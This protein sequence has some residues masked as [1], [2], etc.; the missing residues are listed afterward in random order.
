MI[1]RFGK[2]E[3]LQVFKTVDEISENWKTSSSSTFCPSGTC[4][5]HVRTKKFKFEPEKFLYYRARAITCDV[6]NSNG[7]YF[8][9]EEVKKAYHTFIGKGVYYN[10]DADSVDKSFG[11]ILDA[12]FSPEYINEWPPYVE[13]LACIDKQDI[14]KKRPGL[15]SKIIEGNLIGTS[16][17][18]IAQEAQCSYCSHRYSSVEAACDHVR[19][20]SPKYCKGSSID[21]KVVYENNFGLTFV[22][23]SIVPCPADPTANILKILGS[24]SLQSH[25]LKYW[26]IPSKIEME[27][28]VIKEAQEKEEK[29]EKGTDI[30][31]VLYTKGDVEK[32]VDTLIATKVKMMIKNVVDEYLQERLPNLPEVVQKVEPVIEEVVTEK[33]K[34]L[35]KVTSVQHLEDFSLW[36]QDEKLK[37]IKAILNGEQFIFKGGI[38]ESNYFNL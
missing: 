28:S 5:F 32:L 2:V 35:E 12:V 36:E 13:I 19:P 29:T 7:D 30:P 10:H 4:P 17:G 14:E 16:M 9:T 23:D 24:S 34:E 37:L 22:E 38:D 20:N 1:L 3:T 27:G 6:P 31:D 26:V 25:F 33:A 11:I 15:L 21:G 8:S 18:C